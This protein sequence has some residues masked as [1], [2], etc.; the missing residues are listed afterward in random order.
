MATNN[1]MNGELSTS[2][3]LDDTNNEMLH[4]K[5]AFLLNDRDLLEH[6]M[7]VKAPSSNKA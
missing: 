2:H 6:L 5:I 3:K 7:V 1:A 4:Q